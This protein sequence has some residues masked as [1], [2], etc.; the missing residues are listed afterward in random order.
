MSIV[1]IIP[2]R[3]RGYPQGSRLRR[4]SPILR[5][6]AMAVRENITITASTV[7]KLK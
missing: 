1:K 3:L 5:D 2:L 6:I 4:K 7:R